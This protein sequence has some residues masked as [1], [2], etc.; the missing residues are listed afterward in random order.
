MFVKKVGR[1]LR[2]RI[3]HWLFGSLVVVIMIQIQLVCALLRLYLLNIGNWLS[4]E[5]LLCLSVLLSEKSKKVF[6]LHL[7]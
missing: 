6:F 4:E 3:V 2:W 1:K 7:F 5:D